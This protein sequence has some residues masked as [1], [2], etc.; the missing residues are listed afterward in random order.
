MAPKT[1]DRSQT[2]TLC[3]SLG[4]LLVQP[5]PR[6]ETLCV[7]SNHRGVRLI[8]MVA[9]IFALMVLH[10][11]ARVASPRSKPGFAQVKFSST[12]FPFFASYLKYAA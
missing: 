9:K 1:L 2:I 8:I 7:C 12:R 5:S 11:S 4:E 3:R 6:N 10:R